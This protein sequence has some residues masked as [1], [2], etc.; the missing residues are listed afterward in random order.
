MGK[1]NLSSPPGL[2]KRNFSRQTRKD[3][4]GESADIQEG[5][6]LQLR[7]WSKVRGVL[8]REGK[9]VSEKHLDLRWVGRILNPSRLQF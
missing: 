3:F 2:V 6:K 7:P 5:K 1:E 4:V 9:P 8:V